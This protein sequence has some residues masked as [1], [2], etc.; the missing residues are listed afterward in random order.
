MTEYGLLGNMTKLGLVFN[1][2]ITEVVPSGL[3]EYI[4]IHTHIY[5]GVYIYI[6]TGVFG[7]LTFCD[8][9][10]KMVF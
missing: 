2:S 8:I 7:N 3:I 6:Y 5:T 4:C 9:L 10:E 1:F